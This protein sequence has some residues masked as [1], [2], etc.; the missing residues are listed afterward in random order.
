MVHD[1]HSHK[2]FLDRVTWNVVRCFRVILILLE[3]KCTR[4]PGMGMTFPE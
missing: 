1:T 2:K 3:K 4:V